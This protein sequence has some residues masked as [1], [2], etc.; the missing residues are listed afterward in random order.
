MF[1][2]DGTTLAAPASWDAHEAVE[3]RYL[4][5]EYLR[6]NYVAGT[7]PGTCLVVSVFEDT[8]GEVTGGWHELAPDIAAVANLPALERHAE[9]E[10]AR[11]AAAARPLADAA[12]VVAARA[13]A[14]TAAAA[15][16]RPT[17]GTVTPRDFLTEPAERIRHTGQGLGQDW[18]TVIHRLLEL[19]VLNVDGQG[20][21]DGEAGPGPTGFDL[22]AA[23]ASTV[24]VSDL[25]ESGSDREELARRAMALVEDV[26]AS[27]EWRR[28]AASPE[29]HVEVPFSI[30]VAAA[31]IP[32][33]VE[34][35]YGPT[36]E[37][38][39][40]T[41]G[42]AVARPAVPVLIRGQIDAVFRD[43][44]GPTAGGPA[45]ES[46]AATDWVILDWKTTSVIAADRERLRAHYGPQLVLYARCWAAAPGVQGPP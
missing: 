31:E 35:D 38:G 27:P 43:A 9:A 36:G 18:G 22:A 21:G 26:L 40:D 19:A 13:A 6:L 29:R 23:A 4:E 1:G 24:E 2:R 10:A 3:K 17:F 11:A 39:C 46:A 41:A 16:H 30:A 8:K 44:S 12:A 15:I 34:V 42:P 37:A 28:I 25:A 14:A 20:G 7:R 33:S 45:R 5:A 32:T